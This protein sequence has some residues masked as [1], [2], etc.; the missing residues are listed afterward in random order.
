MTILR[1]KKCNDWIEGDKKGTYIKCECG[2][3]AI[4]ETKEYCR[5]IGEPSDYEILKDV[6]ISYLQVKDLLMKLEQCD[7]LHNN[8]DYLLEHSDIDLLLNY[9]NKLEREIKIKDAWANEIKCNLWN[10]D[11][12]ENSIPGLKGLVDEA[13]EKSEKIMS[14]DDKSIVWSGS[15]HDEHGNKYVEHKNV[16]CEVLTEFTEEDQKFINS[17]EYKRFWF[18]GEDNEN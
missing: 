3:I 1:C 9:I 5:V 8:C 4:D 7:S 2:A 11:G 18:G 10:Y 16:L 6:D 12:C 13:I 14:C 15:R 17:E